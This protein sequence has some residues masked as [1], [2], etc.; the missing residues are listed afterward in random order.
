MGVGP[1]TS[2]S[3]AKKPRRSGAVIFGYGEAHQKRAAPRNYVDEGR[4]VEC[5]R[6]VFHA[7]HSLARAQPLTRPSPG[8]ATEGVPSAANF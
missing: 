7:L 8:N 5:D 6:F 2:A 4:S 3:E 1:G